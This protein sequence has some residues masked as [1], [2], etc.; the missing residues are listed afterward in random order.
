MC[1]Q[2]KAKERWSLGLCSVICLR[3]FSTVI[4]KHTRWVSQDGKPRPAAH[5]AAQSDSCPM[6][7]QCGVALTLPLLP[8]RFYTCSPMGGE[9]FTPVLVVEMYSH[10]YYLKKKKRFA[11]HFLFLV[12]KKPQ[13]WTWQLL[14]LGTTASHPEH[15]EGETRHMQA[16]IAVHQNMILMSKS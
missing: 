13:P 9:I 5:L 16:G 4:P 2:I 1:V 3:A 6:R 10:Y 11:C 7:W 12:E 15:N 14:N 8:R